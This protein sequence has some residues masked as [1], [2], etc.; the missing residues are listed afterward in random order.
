M[1]ILNHNN[2]N[3]NYEVR[4]EG[5]PI[6]LIHGF[7][8]DSRIWEKQVEELSKTNKVI[9]YDLRGFGKSSLPNGKYSH[10]ED[11][12]E[13]LKELNIQDPK[14]VGHSFGGEIAVEYAL[15]YPNEVNNL[16]LISPSLR[17]VKVNSEWED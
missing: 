2:G 4:G 1:P 6:V 11:L 9:T 7:A 16:V 13:L 14:I 3:I 10:T 15:N 17:G 12:H 5:D 8:L